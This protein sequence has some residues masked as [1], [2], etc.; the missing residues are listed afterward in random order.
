MLNNS[1]REFIEQNIK[2]LLEFIDS[3]MAL[4]MP[5]ETDSDFMT[6]MC[7]LMGAIDWLFQSAC[8]F[9][10]LNGLNRNQAIIT[11][12]LIKIRKLY[13][14]MRIHASKNQLELA[15]I[16]HRPI[17]ETM[18]NMVYMVKNESNPETYDSFVITS[19]MGDRERFFFLQ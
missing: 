11:G 13:R 8:M 9:S 12:H 14:G 15:I 7:E 18:V 19:Y 5:L 3:K 17:I 6:L 1:D 4:Q 2:E 10:K 16:F